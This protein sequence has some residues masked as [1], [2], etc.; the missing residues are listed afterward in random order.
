MINYFKKI[1]SNSIDPKDFP[2]CMDCGACCSHFKV[3]FSIKNNPQY[4]KIYDKVNII[5]E[6][7]VFMKGTENFNKGC[8]VALEGKVG[9]KVSCSIYE[10]RPD[11]CRK[12]ERVLP[13]GKIN[14][15][16]IKA[17]KALDKRNIDK[18]KEIITIK[19]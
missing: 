10:N 7:K 18:S 12:F 9:E 2:E 16:C 5:N 14:P 6:N 13:N 3:Y 8:C 1:F 15:K 4:I 11:V 19:G 17:K